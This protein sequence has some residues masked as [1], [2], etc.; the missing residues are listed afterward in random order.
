MTKRSP[1]AKWKHDGVSGIPAHALDS[2]TAQTAGMD[3]KAAI[4]YA[5]VGAQKIWAGTVSI[6]PDAKT[7]AHHYGELGGEAGPGAVDRSDSQAMRHLTEDARY[8]HKAGDRIDCPLL[9]RV[10]VRVG[11]PLALSAVP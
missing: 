2:N 5:R 6:R 9:P 4:N 10:P 11:R 1:A 3:R 8:L 7:G